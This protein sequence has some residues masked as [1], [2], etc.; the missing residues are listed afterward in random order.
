MDS[1]NLSFAAKGDNHLLLN[2]DHDTNVQHACT[3]III[4]CIKNGRLPARKVVEQ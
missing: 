1:N 3:R 2:L 4:V